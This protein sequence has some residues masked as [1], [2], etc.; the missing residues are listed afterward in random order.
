VASKGNGLGQLA[1]VGDASERTTRLRGG[2]AVEPCG[3]P[4]ILGFDDT[5]RPVDVIDSLALAPF[6][7]GT[8]PHCAAAELDAVRPDKTLLPPGASVLRTAKGGSCDA[9]LAAGDG[10]TIRVM[11]WKGG[12]AEVSVTAATAE[13]AQSVLAAALENAVPPKEAPADVVAIRFWHRSARGSSRATRKI[14]AQPWAAVSANYPAAV[15]DKLQDL[16]TV[17]P[18]GIDGRVLL[19]HGEPGTGKT[20]LLRTLAMQW[21]EWCRVECVLDPEILFN[22]LGYLMDVILADGDEDRPTTPPWRM[23]VLED[24]DELIGGEAK[25]A[26]GQ[27]LSRLLNLT[28]G[29]LGQGRQVLIAIT[30]NEELH[31]LHPAVSRQGRCLA[32]VEMGPFPPAE[33]AAWLGSPTGVTGELTLAE[34]FALRAGKPA[35]AASRTDTGTGQYL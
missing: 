5:D 25:H 16:M 13:L 2:T 18:A 1:A 21:R 22:D 24:C 9:M 4:A 20:S 14:G 35:D 3:V 34:L 19:L 28:D 11:R 10:W 26:S 32:Q 27:A 29:M 17:T 15:R 31:R 8:Q 7:E 23:L 12:S 30:T 33:A 6:I